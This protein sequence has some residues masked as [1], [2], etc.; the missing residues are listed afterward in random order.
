[1]ILFPSGDGLRGGNQSILINAQKIANLRHFA[2]F[3]SRPLAQLAQTERLGAV[4]TR[5]PELSI[6]VKAQLLASIP[7]VSLDSHAQR[8]AH[9][10]SI[11]ISMFMSY[12]CDSFLRSFPNRLWFSGFPAAPDRSVPGHSG[13]DFC[14]HRACCSRNPCS[15]SCP[16]AGHSGKFCSGAE[17]VSLVFHSSCP[18][19]AG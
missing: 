14:I 16:C 18:F 10:Q 15:R 13:R 12:I 19:P 2:P 4:E 3:L 5:N 11:V 6:G 8:P 17:S 7:A 9:C 1:M